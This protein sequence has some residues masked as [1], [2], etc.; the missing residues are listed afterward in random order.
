MKKLVI[1][2]IFAMSLFARTGSQKE[3]PIP[4]C[5]PCTDVR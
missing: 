5:D 2:A 4:M 3:M 1:L